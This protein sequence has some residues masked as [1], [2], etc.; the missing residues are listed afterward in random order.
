MARIP[1]RLWGIVLGGGEGE[2]LKPFVREYFGVDHPKQ[3]CRF[4]GHATMLETTVQRAESI[5]SPEQVLVVGTAHHLPYLM[6]CMA[7]R[8]AGT[9]LLQPSARGTAPG[10]LLP[11]THV[12]HRDPH[13]IVAIFPSDHYIRP[14]GQFIETVLD[15][16]GYL[17]THTIRGAILLAVQ[18][19][20]PETDY[21]WIKSEHMNASSGSASIHKVKGFVEK[22]SRE[23]A[24]ALMNEGWFWNTGI[25]IAPAAELL[26]MISRA[27]PQLASWFSLIPRYL[28]TDW[29]HAIVDN[30]YQTLPTLNFSTNILASQCA[31]LLMV[32]LRNIQWSDWGTKDRVVET[33]ADL[34]QLKVSPNAGSLASVSLK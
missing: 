9:I 30:V 28:G 7:T 15:A 25:V 27:A 13:A 11:L 31:D 19:T 8:P 1:P 29:E 18:P 16:V 26:R 17:R 4:M 2:R 6:D 20:S 3:F 34:G 21:G 10:V 32:P 14:E 24:E 23:H 33:L 12:V 22:P 5:T